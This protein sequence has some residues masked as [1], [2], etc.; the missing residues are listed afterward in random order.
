[1]SVDLSSLR[2]SRE[3]CWQTVESVQNELRAL[4]QTG[5]PQNPYE[6]ELVKMALQAILAE[7][8]FRRVIADLCDA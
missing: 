3:A 4:S 1:M 8:A 6:T 2:A 5:T 7:L